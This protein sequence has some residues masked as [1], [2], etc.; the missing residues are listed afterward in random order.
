MARAVLCLLFTIICSQLRRVVYNGYYPLGQLT[1]WTNL[2]VGGLFASNF[3]DDCGETVGFV[4]NT[5]KVTIRIGVGDQKRHLRL[6][7]FSN[8]IYSYRNTRRQTLAVFPY[9]VT[10]NFSALQ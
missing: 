9:D 7:L 2:I 1:I 4:W 5:R 3:R 8:S 6:L 10:A